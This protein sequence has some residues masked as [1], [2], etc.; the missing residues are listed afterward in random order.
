MATHI[1]AGS[2][3]WGMIVWRIRPPAPGAHSGAAGVVRQ[4]L[5]VGPGGAAVGGPEQARGL[6][7]GVDGIEAGR[8]VPDRHDLGA[9]VAVGEPL[10][11]VGPRLAEVVAAQDGGSVPR[12]AARRRAARP[13]PRSTEMSW[14]GQPSQTG[15]RSRQSRRSAVP[16]RRKA[17]LGVPRRRTQRVMGLSGGRVGGRSHSLQQRAKTVWTALAEP[18]GPARATPA[19]VDLD[20]RR[21]EATSG[22]ERARPTSRAGLPG[23]R[24][25]ARAA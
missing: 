22:V 19:R 16:S 21:V 23:G 10:A 1:R 7:A 17:P 24:R 5:D 14:T 6:D 2:V 25:T 20:R 12:A 15:P 13:S 8:H 3:G 18:R 4:P 9:V 11:G